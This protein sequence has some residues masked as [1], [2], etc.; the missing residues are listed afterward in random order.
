MATISISSI[1]E[2]AAYRVAKKIAANFPRS[3]EIEVFGASP[4][5]MP[6]LAKMYRFN[7]IVRT[8]L[9]VNIQKLLKKCVLSEKYNGN[10]RIKVEI[11]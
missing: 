2:T 10:V 3:E 8:K 11:E 1:N 9:N 5:F 4:A 6:K 7:V